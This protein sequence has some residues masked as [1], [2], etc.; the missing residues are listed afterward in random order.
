MK[1][2]LSGVVAANLDWSPEDSYRFKELVE[3]RELVSV[4]TSIERETDTDELV[5]YLRLV[6]T[7]YPKVDVYI[8]NILIQENRARKLEL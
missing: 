3:Y 6:D 8:D 2:K 7:S 4:V 1:A 5:L